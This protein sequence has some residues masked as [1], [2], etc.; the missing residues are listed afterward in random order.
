MEPAF[1]TFDEVENGFVFGKAFKFCFALLLLDPAD[2]VS[3]VR[4]DGNG[5]ALLLQQGKAVY[6]GEEF[7]DVVCPFAIGADA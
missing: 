1:G 3:A 5:A 6:E 7:A 4:I 2:G